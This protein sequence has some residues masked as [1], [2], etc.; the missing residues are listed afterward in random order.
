MWVAWLGLSPS[1]ECDSTRNGDRMQSISQK[2][3]HSSMGG[4]D[5]RPREGGPEPTN[6][7]EA[8]KGGRENLVANHSERDAGSITETVCDSF[9]P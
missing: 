3:A 9:V 5:G 1:D 2:K 8:V 6:A 4:L 7:A